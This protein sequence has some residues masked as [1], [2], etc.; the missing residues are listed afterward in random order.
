MADSPIKPIVSSSRNAVNVALQ[1][2]QGTIPTDIYGY[3][4]MNTPSGSVNSPL[5]YPQYH[6]D[7]KINQEYGSSTLN[8]DGYV[9]RFD[10][11]KT[12]VIQLKTNILKTFPAY[13]ADEATK[14]G[15]PQHEL[16]GFRNFGI[17]RLSPT[18]GARDQAAT[19]FV[20]VLYQ[21]ETNYRLYATSDMGRAYEVD[22]ASLRCLAPV[23]KISDFVPATPSYVPWIFPLI[24]ATAHP[25]FDPKSQLYYTLN[26]TKSMSDML[27]SVKFL[28]KITSAEKLA[29]F[30]KG[31][32]A[33]IQSLK[34]SRQSKKELAQEIL[35]Y[36]ENG[37]DEPTENTG[38]QRSS[39]MIDAVYILA[40]NGQGNFQRWNITDQKGENIEIVQCVHQMGITQDYVLFSD[41][42]FK[43]TLDVLS[44]FAYN[45]II[46]DFIRYLTSVPQESFTNLYIVKK[47]DLQTSNTDVKAF[48]FK[49]SPEFVHFTCDYLN[50]NQTITLYSANNAAACL[51]EWI[52]FY[53]EL[54]DGSKADPSSAGILATGSM[55]VSRLGKAKI[56]LATMQVEADYLHL[57]GSEPNG[58]GAHTWL[59]GFYTYNGMLAPTQPVNRIEDLYWQC[60]GLENRR[61][62]KF[63]YSL[64]ENYPNRIV[65]LNEVVAYTEK[66]VPFQVS[67]L[68]TQTMQIED[69]YSL[70]KACEI[71]SLQFIPRKRNSPTPPDVLPSRDGYIFCA[72]I[73][74]VNPNYFRREMWLFDAQN[75]AK[76][77]V[78]VLTHP[79]LDFSTALHWVWLPTAPMQ[80]GSIIG[81]KTEIVGL[82]K[83]IETEVKDDITTFVRKFI[84][85]KK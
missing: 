59:A 34:N 7:G 47:T 60:S 71:M 32:E 28:Q 12:G 46:D 55:D 83:N 49:L 9:M 54:I 64:Y 36:F 2:L 61:L 81:H 26:Y 33:K 41:S 35:R 80:R 17:A 5:P 8:G 53:D 27:S 74:E 14:Y 70:P 18:L 38:N 40:Y 22:P 76:G 58:N 69:F 3:A 16:L 42:A 37:G 63:I 67:R 66:G 23:G 21:G 1:I 10:F 68:N 75:L 56:N 77:A 20:P 44:P 79:D 4:F 24:Q 15:T 50:P 82:V 13:Q 6:A 11:S 25:V 39:G 57:T 84:H 65:P 73:N 51:A 30:E 48:S 19:A 72:V 85:K 43:I 52:R 62:S 45:A 29:N 78:C 31:L